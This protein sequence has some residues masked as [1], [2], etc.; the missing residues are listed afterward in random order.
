MARSTPSFDPGDQAAMR[1][2]YAGNVT[3]IDDQIGEIVQVIEER[4]E[5]DNTVIAFTSDHGEM[6]GDW[7]LIYKVNFLDGAL[8]VPMLLRTPHTAGSVSDALVENCDLGPHAGGTGR[9]RIGASSVRA[10]T[11]AGPSPHF[12]PGR[13]SASKS[14][15]VSR[16]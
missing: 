15:W 5:L 10:F 6:H 14:S 1:A 7:D 11:R 12:S 9:R 13:L 4:G 3:L 16:S 2:N 8:R